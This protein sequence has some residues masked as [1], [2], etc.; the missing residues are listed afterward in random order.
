MTNNLID[1]QDILNP[2]DTVEEV[3]TGVD[4][5][6][7]DDDTVDDDSEPE[8]DYKQ[9]YEES[10]EKRK[11]LFA[12]LKR[13]DKSNNK[14]TVE[15]KADTDALSQKD[16]FALMK[17]DISDDD[18]DRVVKYAKS[19]GKTVSDS[20]KDDELKA[21][22]RVRAEKRESAEATNVKGAPRGTNK[23][24]PDAILANARK[25]QLPDDPTKLVEARWGRK[26]K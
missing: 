18:F 3:D 9:L 17:A 12:R 11:Q 23:V 21:I 10:E 24:S 20:L 15:A 5:D 7:N 19:E 22:L 6:T 2:E 4:T 16:L 14:A 8:V 13:E 1:E 26:K 25:G